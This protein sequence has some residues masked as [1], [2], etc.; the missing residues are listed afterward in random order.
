MPH[1]LVEPGRL[2]RCERRPRAGTSTAK[3]TPTTPPESRD[4]VELRVR[5]VARRRA[6]RVGVRVRRDERSRRVSRDVPEA[7]ARSGA[8]R[9]RGS[10]AGC[11]RGRASRPASVSPAPVSGDAGNAERHA[12]G[13]RVRPR[14]DD[15]DRAQAAVVPV[16]RG[17]TGRRAIGSAPSMCTIAVTSPALEVVDR[18]ALGATGSAHSVVEE[19]LGDARRLVERDRRRRAA[20]RTACAGG[21]AVVRRRDVEREEPAARSPPRRAVVEVDVLRRLL[22][23]PALAARGR[24]DRRSPL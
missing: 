20:S 3:L 12:F 5:E 18:R 14:P 24:C 8:T 10:R 7:R 23:A 2:G 1:D 22:A 13:E 9:R 17:S 19:L 11:R 15:A 6:Q 4:R 16:A 21:S